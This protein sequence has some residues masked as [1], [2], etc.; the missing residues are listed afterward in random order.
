MTVNPD[1]F[2]ARVLAW[3]HRH[4]RRD[5]PWQQQPTS[6]RV[7]VSEIMLQQT[8]V[9]TVIP[10]YQRFMETFPDIR[11]LAAAPEDQVLHHWSGLGYY[12]RARNLH[13]AA[14]QIVEKHAGRFPARFEEVLALPGIGE[15][16]AG[17]VLSLSLGQRHTILD[18]NVKRVLARV[19]MVEG[20]PGRSPVQ[21][22][23]WE[24]ARQ[25]TPEQEVAAYNQA[26]MDLGATVCLRS[27]PDCAGCPVMDCCQ[28]HGQDRV[29]DFPGRRKAA[30]RRERSVQMLVICNS[31]GEVLLRKRPPTGIWGGLW[32]FPEL[33]M[34]DKPDEWL[35]ARGLSAECIR[36]LAP[37][38]HSFSH[39]HLHI[40]P[41]LI[42]QK[43][44]G[45][46]VLDGDG[47]VWYNPGNGQRRGLSAPVQ[48]LLLELQ[49]IST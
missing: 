14:R 43:K 37:R 4:G 34:D 21:R 42:L 2:A 17:A 26:M 30:K 23:L 16:T 35:A 45:C 22:R 49:R 38:R 32:S 12:A 6:Y 46:Q 10:Y 47:Q 41:L 3:F 39:F 29:R 15:S 40:H 7:W 44:T 48:Q 18:G 1:I 36:E 19:F 5:L 9:R 31:E 28:A 33:G 13:R 11:S 24:I 27:R 8:Q 20:W 25:L